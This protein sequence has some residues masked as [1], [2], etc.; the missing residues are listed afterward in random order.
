MTRLPVPEWI[1]RKRDGGALSADDLRALITGYVDG[2]VP[3]YQMSAM[4]MAIFFRGMSPEETTSL[5]LAMRDSGETIARGS[6]GGAAIDKH[7]TGGVGDKVS[8]ALAPLVACLG[9]KVPMICGR[10]LGHTGGTVDKME[11]IAGFRARLGRDE[12]RAIVEREGAVIGGQSESLAPA[13]RSLYALRDV[14]GT[15]ESIPLITASI[16]SKKLAEGLDGLVIDVKCG[17]GAFM[18]TE[19]DARAL[20]DSLTSVG[21]A[22]GVPVTAMLTRM[23]APLGRTIGNALEVREAIEILDGRGDAELVAVTRALAVEMSRL[24][25]ID[26]AGPAIDR[27]LASGE[28]REKLARIVAAQG[29]DRRAIDDPEHHLPIAP[30]IRDVLS[31][32]SGYVTAI[33]ALGLGVAA[34]DLGAGRRRSDEA[35]DPSVGFEVLVRVGDRVEI[36][37]PIGRVHART[38]PSAESARDA[39]GHAIELAETAPT[40]R[41]RILD[42]LRR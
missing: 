37:Q 19:S 17:R 32:A 29:G 11:S 36:G 21:R 1:R 15:V 5:T 13:D 4:A 2:S 9:V 35:V 12:L 8:I 26:D 24:A 27:L 3:D 33:D 25:R 10:G 23:D 39:L 7:S 18:K 38:E 14:T 42:T 6:Y 22:S 20:A 28:A 30:S 34:I 31:A 41:S 40:P 16:L